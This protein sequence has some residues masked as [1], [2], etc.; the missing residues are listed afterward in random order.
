MLALGV[1]NL[2]MS[3]PL[4]VDL[5]AKKLS[6]HGNQNAKAY[7]SIIEN[8]L[9]YESFVRKHPNR[10]NK[11]LDQL[12]TELEIA[13]ARKEKSEL[14][15]DYKT[16][17]EYQLAYYNSELDRFNFEEASELYLAKEQEMKLQ[18]NLK[19]AV[20][21]Y[22][23]LTSAQDIEEEIE[24]KFNKADTATL[25]DV[26]SP[27]ESPQL[28]KFKE[29]HAQIKGLEEGLSKISDAAII[30]AIHASIA[31]L[32][33]DQNKAITELQ[34]KIQVLLKAFSTEFAI[35]RRY[36]NTAHLRR[37]RAEIDLSRKDIAE[38]EALEAESKDLSL[39]L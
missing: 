33:D 8:A 4:A 39:K 22:H 38:M 18:A 31:T 37:L 23:Q 19:A 17:E 7:Q 10:S 14:R 28:S 29:V 1:T 6:L 25:P 12:Q 26:E 13:K 20:E 34:D 9:E 36:R 30:A 32:K 5:V 11:T 16:P 35:D 2:F 3:I 24:C 15:N 27:K 21:N